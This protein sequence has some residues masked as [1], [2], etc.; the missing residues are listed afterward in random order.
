[1][2]QLEEETAMQKTVLIVDDDPDIIT[3]I[4]FGLEQHGIA[5]IE[6]GDGEEALRTTR[7]EK[8]D[9][10]VLDVMLPGVSGYKVARLLKFD[11]SQ[12]T[13]PIIMLTGRSD[14][15]DRELGEETGADV[16]VT[17]PFDIEALTDLIKDHLGAT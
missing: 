14:E 2:P 16:Y 12:A 8:P 17:K 7:Q 9:L 13:I 6:A 11:R 10:I 15:K 4:R 5:C 3:A 1:L